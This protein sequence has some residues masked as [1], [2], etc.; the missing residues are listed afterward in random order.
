[1]YNSS[2]LLPFPKFKFKNI[3]IDILTFA[4][5]IAQLVV[6]NGGI[7]SLL[8]VILCRKDHSPVSAVL[9]LGFIGAMS[10]S[11]ALSVIESKVLMHFKLLYFIKSSRYATQHPYN[12]LR[13]QG[14]DAF[15]RHFERLQW[16]Q[17]F[18]RCRGLGIGYDRTTW[19]QTCQIRLRRW[20]HNHY[21][22][23]KMEK[24]WGL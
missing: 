15:R 10:P 1:M 12:H 13:F 23:G 17:I 20:C 24:H 7:A 6:S 5:Q 4:L 11:L 19:S 22:G 2:W 21:D 14:T 18:E 9:A 3:N 16:G 8:N